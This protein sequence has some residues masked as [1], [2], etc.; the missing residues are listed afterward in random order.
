MQLEIEQQILDDNKGILRCAIVILS[1][2]VISP[3]VTAYAQTAS[4]TQEVNDASSNIRKLTA[5]I[6]ACGDKF[7]IGDMSVVDDCVTVI[8]QFNDAIEK[9]VGDN[10]AIFQEMV[11]G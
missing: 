11:F 8:S 1:L 5:F 9:I 4:D 3:I 10:S 2:L 7:L 6:T